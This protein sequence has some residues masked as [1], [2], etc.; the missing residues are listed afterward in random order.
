MAASVAITAQRPSDRVV[1]P[2]TNSA[3][4]LAESLAGVEDTIQPALQG[5][6]K[7]N[8]ERSTA[9][10]N[11]DVLRTNGQKLADAVRDGKIEKTQ[12]PYYIQAYER[13]AG[14]VSA[15]AAVSDL[16]DQSQT[17]AERTDTKAYQAKFTQSLGEIAKDYAGNPDAFDGFTAAANP[18]MAQALQQNEQYNVARINQE[19]DANSG[20]LAT[21]AILAVT[22]AKAGR[23]APSD[24]Y[25]AL[26]PQHKNWIATGGTESDW[27]RLTINAV[28]AAAYNSGNASLLDVLDD[29]RGGKGALS[30]IVG[31]DGQPVAASIATS[32]YRIEQAAEERGMSAIKA[33]ANK[34]K[35][36]GYTARQEVWDHFGIAFLDGGVNQAAIQQFL[37]GTGKYSPQGIAAA[38]SIMGKE[39]GEVNAFTR[40]TMRGDPDVFAV[41][42]TA[43]RNGYTPDL[44][45]K[46]S[47]MLRKGE[48]D[49]QEAT[50][51]LGTAT[52]RSNHLES[53]ARSDARQNKSD[54]RA[55]ARDQKALLVADAKALKDSRT[56]LSGTVATKMAAAGIHTLQSP[57]ARTQFDKGLQDAESYALTRSG[58]DVNTARDAVTAYAT[59]YMRAEIQR[60]RGKPS[61]AKPASTG[62]SNPRK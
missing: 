59:A 41:Y 1:A 48:I 13:G 21:T 61:A 37:V 10:A 39:L 9:Q 50:S 32:K 7:A 55:A 58:N 60:K 2:S 46:V 22:Q 51:I 18:L 43:N 16:I 15:R 30:S 14:A 33:Q 29:P 57:K 6:A 26:E 44:E 62:G 36:E 11:A 5:L 45:T 19:H 34:D 42:A 31:P 4:R 49:L 56:Q 20:Q 28:T 8:Q 27:D 23:P 24:V 52:A 53:E 47:D 54:A 38:F 40:A 3:T 35:L 25:G 17:W 12:N